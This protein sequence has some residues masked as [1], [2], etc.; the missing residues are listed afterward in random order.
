MN[1]MQGFYVVAGV[2][3]ISLGVWGAVDSC[4]MH[5]A[6]RALLNVMFGV[7]LLAI[8]AIGYKTFEE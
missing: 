8:C 7:S 6:D 2:V 5:D 3:A 1:F 4:W